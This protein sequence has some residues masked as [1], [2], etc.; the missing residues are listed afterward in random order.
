MTNL[1]DA[2]EVEPSGAALGAEVRGVDFAKPIPEAVCSALNAIWAEHLVLLFRGLSLDDETLL[3]TADLF[4]GR[5]VAGSRAFLLK[6]G[7]QPGRDPRLSQTAEVSIVSNLDEFGNPVRVTASTGSL[8]L[9][10][11]TDN[12]YVEVPPKG[13]LLHAHVV[14]TDGGGDTSFNNQYL[15]YERL[16]ERLK[17]RIEGLHVRHDNARN[18]SGR[19]RPT[20]SQPK[21]RVDITG[22][23]HPIVR[24]HPITHRR[25]L[26][27]GRHYEW[28][29]SHIVELADDESEAVLSELW[30]Y[31]TADDLGWTHRWRAGDLLLWDNQCTMHARSAIDPTQPRVMHRALVKGTPVISPWGG[32]ASPR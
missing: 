14:P 19:L 27:L 21:S 20:V 8:S 23:V 11:H 24:V 15:A 17:S 28:P 22:P 6:A 32:T 10:W 13:S 9:K 1:V 12:S 16:P 30:D 4:G 31:A 29:S 18:T 2:I 3:R 5:Q 26:Y 7:H 25:A